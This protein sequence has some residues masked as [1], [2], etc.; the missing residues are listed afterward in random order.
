MANSPIRALLEGLLEYTAIA[1]LALLAGTLTGLSPAQGVGAALAAFIGLLAALVGLASGS[2]ILSWLAVP[3]PFAK[4]RL[5][6]FCV[7]FA[8][9]LALGFDLHAKEVGQRSPLRVVQRW[10][11][12]GCSPAQAR[13][14]AAIEILGQDPGVL[15]EK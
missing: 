11:E 15:P 14:M 1:A 10:E 5:L 3:G 2:R 13:R 8:F 12:A 9:G 7:C 6:V 4:G